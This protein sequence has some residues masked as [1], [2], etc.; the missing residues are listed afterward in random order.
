MDWN[1]CKVDGG[2]RIG[3]VVEDKM[4]EFANGGVGILVVIIALVFSLVAW[5]VVFVG[6][7]VV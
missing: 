6:S 3:V 1:G 2:P 5:F 7:K 4:A